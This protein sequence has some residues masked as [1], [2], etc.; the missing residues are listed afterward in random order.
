MFRSRGLEVQN[1]REIIFCEN[2]ANETELS[3]IN[4][5][6]NAQKVTFAE[7]YAGAD[8]VAVY[9]AQPLSKFPSPFGT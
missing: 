9:G 4:A 2:L 5:V 6:G 3:G 8:T 7:F 1:L